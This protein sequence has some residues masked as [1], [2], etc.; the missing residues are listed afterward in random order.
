MRVYQQEGTHIM[1]AIIGRYRVQ[2]EDGRLMLKHTVGI[3]FDLTAEET[4]GLYNFISVYRETLLALCE[5]ER[6][7]DP[8][9]QRIILDEDDH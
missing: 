9:L 5:G 4:L 7:T 2:M 1:D 8:R 6:E 3:N